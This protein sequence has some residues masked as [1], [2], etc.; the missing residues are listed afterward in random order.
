MLDELIAYVRMRNRARWFYCV[1]GALQTLPNLR[2]VICVLAIFEKL[3]HYNRL[4]TQKNEVTDVVHVFLTNVT[5][6]RFQLH[7]VI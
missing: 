5:R 3:K 7:A 6:L 1:D 4:A 2:L